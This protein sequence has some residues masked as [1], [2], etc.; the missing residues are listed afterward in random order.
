MIEESTLAGCFRVC[1][2]SE[3]HRISPLPPPCGRPRLPPSDHHVVN[4]SR[5]WLMDLRIDGWSP[6][7]KQGAPNRPTENTLLPS[8][9]N[10]LRVHLERLS[11]LKVQW[12]SKAANWVSRRFLWAQ[13]HPVAGLEEG[14]GAPQGHANCLALGGWCDQQPCIEACWHGPTHRVHGVCPGVVAS[15]QGPGSWA[16]AHA[17]TLAHV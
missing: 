4:P 3:D 5:L 12:T 8:E 13:W 9:G 2:P 17:L 7:A 11:L 16:Q 10:P 6:K 1:S 15:L 14:T